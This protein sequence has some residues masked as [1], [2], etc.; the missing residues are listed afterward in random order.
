MKA[1]F[2]EALMLKLDKNKTKRENH[3]PSS[4]MNLGA[5]ILNKIFAH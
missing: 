5:K 4:L 1:L 2:H 3:R